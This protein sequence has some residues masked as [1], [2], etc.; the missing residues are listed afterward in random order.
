[1]ATR[2]RSRSSAILLGS[3]AEVDDIRNACANAGRE[4]LWCPYGC[5]AGTA[6]QTVLAQRGITYGLNPHGSPENLREAA[7]D[8]EASI[9]ADTN[10]L[11]F[12]FKKGTEVE[13]SLVEMSL[14]H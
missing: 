11:V 7:V 14:P 1:M 10:E 13:M 3:V 12:Q 2:G 9:R 5:T 4:A 6:G 8:P